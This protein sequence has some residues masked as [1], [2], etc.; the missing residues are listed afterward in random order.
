MLEMPFAA[1]AQA[2]AV[3]YAKK[4]FAPSVCS[5]NGR[6]ASRLTRKNR[7]QTAVPCDVSRSVAANSIYTRRVSHIESREAKKNLARTRAPARTRC[8]LIC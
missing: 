1:D 5:A 6:E 3:A 2:A 8:L 4:F 7:Q